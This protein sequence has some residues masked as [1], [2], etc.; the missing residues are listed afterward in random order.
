LKCI[1]E[2]N[3]VEQ[4]NNHAGSTKL[5]I[6]VGKWLKAKCEIGYG[7]AYSGALL[8]SFEE[9]L[10]DTAA[11]QTSPGVIAFG[12]EMNR[13]G[14][15]RKR[16]NG[17]AHMT[18]LKLLDRPKNVPDRR[19]DRGLATMVQAEEERKEREKQVKNEVKK[20][21]GET[22]AARSVKRRMKKETKERIANVGLVDEL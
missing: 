4:G 10:E 6:A 5:E 11:L 17:Q 7:T 13:R 9:F 19:M 16:I 3:V 18:G 21:M 15:G 22:K 14:F 8:S 12:R 2:L 1:T 20:V